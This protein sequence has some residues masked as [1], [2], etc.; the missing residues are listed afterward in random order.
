MVDKLSLMDYNLEFNMLKMFSFSFNCDHQSSFKVTP[1]SL[2]GSRGDFFNHRFYPLSELCQIFWH[3]GGVYFCFDEAP[4]LKV[5]WSKVW[6]PRWPV[7]QGGVFIRSAAD[8][9]VWQTLVQEVPG[10]KG[11]VRGRAVLLEDAAPGHLWQQPAPQQGNVLLKLNLSTMKNTLFVFF[12][13]VLSD[14]LK[15]FTFMSDCSLFGNFW[16]LKIFFWTRI[17]HRVFV[18]HASYFDTQNVKVL[19][20]NG[21]NHMHIQW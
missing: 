6:W 1:H 18:L 9:F 8:P 5:K 3:L 15:K 2:Q 7:N 21:V 17:K 11:P 14:N 13:Y 16:V 10:N 12:S 19:S 20:F 4:K